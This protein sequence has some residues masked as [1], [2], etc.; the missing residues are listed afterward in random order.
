M[1]EMAIVGLGAWG[2]C[3]LERTVNRARRVGTPV[4]VHVVEPARLGGVYTAAQP[5]FLV[6][7]NACGQLSLYAAPDGDGLPPYA[8][9]LHAWAVVRG[10]RWVGYE[11]RI[12]AGGDP[13]L[14]TDYLPRRLMG[15]YLGWFYDTVVADAP[16]NLEIVRHY[17][18]A[19]D[20]SPALQ[21]REAVLLENG[22]T[23]TVDHVV[24]TSG[25]T[26]NDEPG[27]A[28]GVRYLPPY[29]VEHFDQ[30]A[31]AGSSV[32]MAGMGL[33]CFDVLT[34]LTIGRGGTFVDRCD[35]A[36][37][38]RYV[39][40]GREPTI[41]LYSRSGAPYLAKAAHGVDPYGRYQPVVCTP[42]EFAALTNP[43][44]SPVRRHVDFRAE[45]LPLIFAEM[46]ARYY[47][48][49]ALLAGGDVESTDVRAA[50]RQG[51]VDGH[52]EK[53]VDGLEPR[54]GRF[55]PGSHLFAGSDRHYTSAGDYQGQVYDMI[56]ADLTEALRPGGSPVKAAQEVLRIL[57][58]QLRSVIEFGGLSLESYVD[59]QSNIRPRINRLEAGC[60]PMRSQQ[61]LALLDAG[62]VRV[63]L[64]PSPELTARPD[65]VRL[66]STALDEPTS[67]TVDGVV[68]GYLDLPSLA[69]SSSPLLKR[70]YAKGRLTQL[71]YGDTPVGSVAINEDFHPYDTEGRL[72]PNLSLL[73]VLTEGVRY[74]THYLPSPRSRLRAVYD[75]QDCVE[76]VIG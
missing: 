21:G 59:F 43:G 65:G 45:L 42:E 7:N 18:A 41:T 46:Q 70:L 31:P 71:T 56:E 66:S 69:R 54:Y 55:D 72:Q 26:W 28:G 36:D 15:E 5:D 37:R 40:S 23:L 4:R 3:V 53:V 9:G 57:R 19:V 38:K 58:D 16:P 10:Y 62:V 2:L 8:V 14:P 44:G 74:F 6:L 49:A 51:W 24:L 48:H 13:I 35:R 30:S 32:A 33:A 20:I 52:Y 75:A 12:G 27:A 67:V 73:G 76:A 63:P 29:P 64:G 17:A 1:I 50:L 47:I 22:T 11:C 25:H 68:R 61:L 34:A 60:P 39:P